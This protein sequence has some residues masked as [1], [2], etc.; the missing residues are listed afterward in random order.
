MEI[1][2]FKLCGRTL[3]PPQETPLYGGE[4]GAT[5]L[6]VTGARAD[7]A[8]KLDLLNE[9][10]G[11]KN[12][13]DLANTGGTLEVALTGEAS[14]PA[15]G[16]RLQLRT[17]GDVVWH[18]DPVRLTV[19]EPIDAVE[20]FAAAPTEMRQ[21]ERRVTEAVAAAEALSRETQAEK[22]DKHDPIG[23]GSFSLNRKPG[24]LY[25]RGSVTLCGMAGAENEATGQCAV[26]VGL[27]NAADGAQAIAAGNGTR[28]EGKNSVALGIGT[29]VTGDN[30]VVEGRYT[31]ASGAYQHVFGRYNA[32]DPDKTLI[33]GNGTS[34]TDRKN[35]MTLSRSGN[36]AFAGTVTAG[37]KRLATEERVD[38]KPIVFRIIGVETYTLFCPRGTTW[39]QLAASEANP[40]VHLCGSGEDAQQKTVRLISSVNAY[41]VHAWTEYVMEPQFLSVYPICTAPG[42][43]ENGRV[44]QNDTITDGA[45]YYIVPDE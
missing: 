33:V 31:V 20:S 44:G 34:E 41:G 6:R 38:A 8:Y 16:Y 37:G 22:L 15:G 32:A 21:I 4:S 12:T 43:W 27:K 9:W 17:V 30:S 35:V 11:L 13:L 26:A 23:T 14:I 40:I 3:T 25:G 2:E 28:A 45:T 19:R 18:S 1:L 24:T 10:N 36:A 42:A 5:V 39:A 7:L 29:T